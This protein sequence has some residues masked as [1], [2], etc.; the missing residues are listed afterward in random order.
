MSKL[1]S[2]QSIQNQVRLI[3]E[4]LKLDES[5]YEFLKEPNQI[6]TTNFPVMMD[7]E[8]VKMF[9]GYK[10][11]HNN[12]LGPYKAG[13]RFKKENDLEE[14][15][16]ISIL[17][18]L[19]SS[20]AGIPFGGGIGAVDVD[21]KEL[22]D[23]ELERLSRAYL[24]SI[25]SIIGEHVDIPGP[26]VGTNEQVMAWMCE[27]Y[28]SLN[29]ADHY[30]S[31][32]GKPLTY[33]GS[34]GRNEAPGY[35]VALITNQVLKNNKEDLEK[36]SASIQGFG[37]VGSFTALYLTRFGCKIVAISDENHCIFKQ[38]GFL[39]EEIV[40]YYQKNKTFLGYKDV[41][42]CQEADCIYEISCDLFFPCATAN[43]LNEEHASRLK[44][45]YVIEGANGPTTIEGDKIMQEKG[46]L[47]VP[48]VLANC[49]GVVVSYFEWLQNLYHE[50]W[51]FI[52]VQEKQKTL[53]LSAYQSIEKL[54]AEKKVCL[55]EACMLFSIKNIYEK[56]EE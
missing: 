33:F 15:K 30:A 53:M 37:K 14:L 25:N 42:W 54:R 41:D 44:V 13:T 55:R 38:D 31:V 49:G 12:V 9:R 40:A 34:L 5:I 23:S 8:K 28:R 50:S 18:T 11:Q 56:M 36:T 6:L 16:A 43:V 17:K 45:R 10:V 24:R 19:K 22:S 2:F 1:S 52:E 46:I 3:V 26:D 51:S 7:N 32:T 4:K 27:E 20:I 47:V 21:P 39:V 29:H 48:D 35:G